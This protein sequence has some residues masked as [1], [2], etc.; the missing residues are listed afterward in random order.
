M[1]LRVQFGDAHQRI[2]MQKLYLTQKL[3]VKFE[4]NIHYHSPNFKKSYK[5]HNIGTIYSLK[6]QNTKST[7]ETDSVQEEK[8][9]RKMMA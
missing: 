7:P 4:K 6:E 9:I 3:Q 5:N 8:I 2:V 1:C